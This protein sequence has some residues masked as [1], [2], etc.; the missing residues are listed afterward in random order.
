MAS[1]EIFFV[2]KCRVAKLGI[3]NGDR[4]TVAACCMKLPIACFDSG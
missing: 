2:E 3:K 1:H 4:Y